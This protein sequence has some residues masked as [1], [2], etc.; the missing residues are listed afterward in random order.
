M[1]LFVIVHL[2]CLFS[3]PLQLPPYHPFFPQLVSSF[4][5]LYY[6]QAEISATQLHSPYNIPMLVDLL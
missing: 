2:P 3:K 4:L 6:I 5:T 1:I